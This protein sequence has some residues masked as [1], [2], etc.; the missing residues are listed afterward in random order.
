MYEDRIP[1]ITT[2]TV[3]TRIIPDDEERKIRSRFNTTCTD[4]GGK[5]NSGEIIRYSKAGGAK[6]AICLKKLWDVQ[7]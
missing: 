4:C 7:P 2:R 3:D 6:H 1:R 5:I